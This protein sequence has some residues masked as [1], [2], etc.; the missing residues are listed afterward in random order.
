MIVYKDESI[1][2]TKAENNSSLIKIMYKIF[3]LKQFF[4]VNKNDLITNSVV[5]RV[6]NKIMRISHQ[7]FLVFDILIL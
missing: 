7:I 3:L 1:K 4:G 2:M 6:F 5:N